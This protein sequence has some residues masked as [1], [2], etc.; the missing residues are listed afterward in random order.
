VNL[1]KV[2]ML[3]PRNQERRSGRLLS[4]DKDDQ[5]QG[6]VFYDL[7]LVQIKLWSRDLGWSIIVKDAQHSTVVDVGPFW[8]EGEAFEAMRT[9][10]ANKGFGV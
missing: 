8:T 10:L 9:A 6:A 5:L 2:G 3:Q 4:P 1:N 7:D